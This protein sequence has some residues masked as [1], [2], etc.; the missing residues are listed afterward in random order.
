MEPVHIAWH[1][2]FIE[3]IQLEL[4]PYKDSL[5]FFPEY[6]L[7]DEPLRIDCIV[8]KKAKGVVI[9]KNIAKIFREFNIFE[10][11]SPD[12]YVSLDDFYKVYAYACLYVALKRVPITGMTISFVGSHYPKKLIGH[13]KNARGYKVEE[14]SAGIYSV[15]GDIIPIQLIDSRKLPG[16]DNLWLKSLSNRLNPLEILKISGEAVKQDK[17]ARIQAFLY[18]ITQGNA[19][20][21]EEARR[22]SEAAVTLE[23]VIERIGLGAKWEA[24]GEARGETRGEE[25]KALDIAQN[26]INLGYTVEDVISATK[27][28]QEKVKALSHTLSLNSVSFS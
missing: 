26:M 15:H 12:D 10:Y 18:A 4:K 1:P 27:L 7:T 25:R 14:S 21:L 6:P 11:K 3:A 22:M 9:E 24:I 20:V 2:A 19:G 28:D 8:I 13:F 23:D 17:A 5:E 16:E